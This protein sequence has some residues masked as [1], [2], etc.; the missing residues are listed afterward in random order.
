MD[1][2]LYESADADIFVSGAN[3]TYI[4]GIGID[5]DGNAHP[6]I[7]N[8]TISFS[9]SNSE[10][11][12]GIGIF[13]TGY[14]YAIENTI[15]N[16]YH[17]ID[18]YSDGYLRGNTIK[19]Y[20]V[21]VWTEAFLYLGDHLV[22]ST[23]HV[24]GRNIFD[25]SSGFTIPSTWSYF[26]PNLTDVFLKDIYFPSTPTVGIFVKNGGNKFSTASPLTPHWHIYLDLG[27]MTINC[28]KNDWRSASTPYLHF[29]TGTNCGSTCGTS[30]TSNFCPAKTYTGSCCFDGNV[31]EVNEHTANPM[32]VDTLEIVDS[33]ETELST[34]YLQ[35]I[36]DSSFSMVYRNQSLH[37]AYDSAAFTDD[38]LR[39]SRL[40]TFIDTCLLV[41]AKE[42]APPFKRKIRMLI[43][44]AYV[45]LQDSANAYSF[46][47]QITDDNLFILD[48][49]V[50]AWRMQKLETGMNNPMPSDDLATKN[51]N[52]VQR[53]RDDILRYIHTRNSSPDDTTNNT[54]LPPPVKQS[55]IPD[56]AGLISSL[57]AIPNPF[58]NKTEFKFT[59][60][61]TQAIK[62]EIYSILGRKLLVKD[63]GVQ[64]SGE[65]SYELNTEKW[66]AG[67]YLTRFVSADGK[68]STISLKRE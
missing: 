15:Q 17:A 21:G 20:A 61:Y 54:E 40:S 22:G 48:S 1:I 44:D 55:F 62:L 36:G 63:L 49:L 67:T 5:I 43:A 25:F 9:T 24:L 33:S 50:A 66:P 16:Y 31:T 46:Y 60:A 45:Q 65:N 2:G 13:C 32:S 35:I 19:N 56:K 58:T 38:S 59:L 23:W 18:L 64:S 68:V 53:V 3:M 47:K 42:Q 26:S 12:T 57:I 10:T 52:Y 34:D 28:L 30:Y 8:S 27:S 6:T 4:F 41:L 29:I 11:T 51:S 14:L 37:A 39:I 7:C